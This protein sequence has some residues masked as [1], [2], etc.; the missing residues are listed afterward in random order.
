VIE[1][2][3]LAGGYRAYEDIFKETLLRW[4][5]VCKPTTHCEVYISDVDWV[6][7][8]IGTCFDKYEK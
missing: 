5:Y 2:N 3:V 4:R 8:S 1:I 7:G 6:V